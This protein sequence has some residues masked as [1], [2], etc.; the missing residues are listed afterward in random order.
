MTKHVP[1]KPVQPNQSVQWA[2]K[3]LL[4]LTSTSQPVTCTE[5]SERLGVER[6]KA[7]RLLGTLAYLGMAE[8]LEDLSYIPGSGIHALSSMSLRSSGLLQHALPHIQR[9]QEKWGMSAA[10]GVLWRDQVSFL[11]HSGG[12]REVAESIAGAK[13][14]PVAKSALGRVLLAQKTDD[15]IRATV[16]DTLPPA[17][18]RD[19]AVAMKRIR[20][21]GYVL[22]EGKGISMA[23][24]T[25]AT[26]GLRFMGGY[27]AS[28]SDELVDDVRAVVEDIA[29]RVASPRRR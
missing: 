10:L 8:R 15:E 12:H 24:G 6:T 27:D 7:S 5:M 19:L 3:C 2:I 1:T 29:R 21:A 9:M 13:P 26:A 25:P 17:E 18:W 28:R 22:H 20:R 11:Y 16:G 4:E 14:W 23:I